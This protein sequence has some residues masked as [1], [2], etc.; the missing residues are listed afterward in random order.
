[1]SQLKP[2]IESLLRQTFFTVHPL[3]RVPSS[4]IKMDFLTFIRSF[5]SICLLLS[6]FVHISQS[7]YIYTGKSLSETISNTVTTIPTAKTEARGSTYSYYY[8][9]RII[10]YIPLY[11]LFY[12]A[13]YCASVVIRTAYKYYVRFF[14]GFCFVRKKSM[15]LKTKFVAGWN[16]STSEEEKGPG[17]GERCVG[18]G[19]MGEY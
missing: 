1:M 11:Y 15:N 8:I 12:F 6:I 10:Y 18:N 9:S 17:L 4:N 16:K 19:D 7:K 3:V 13:I 2:I 14:S 5:F